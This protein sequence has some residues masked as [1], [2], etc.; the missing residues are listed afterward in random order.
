M[1]PVLLSLV[2]SG[3]TRWSHDMVPNSYPWVADSCSCITRATLVVVLSTLT[4]WL[5]LYLQV[6]DWSN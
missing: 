4:L 6:P 2:R 1:P 5:P 3:V